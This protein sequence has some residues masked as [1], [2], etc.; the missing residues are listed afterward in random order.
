[1]FA[2]ACNKF[3]SNVIEKCL[4][5]LSHDA[6]HEMIQ[7]LYSVTEEEV[8]QMLQDSFG[9]YIIQ[10]SIALASIKDIWMI[11]EKL[12]PVLQRTPYGHKIES[13]L[14]RRLKGKPVSTRAQVSQQQTGNSNPVNAPSRHGSQSHG[15]NNSARSSYSNNNNDQYTRG[16]RVYPSHRGGQHNPNHAANNSAYNAPLDVPAAQEPW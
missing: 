14:E 3:S 4:F 15:G 6:Q 10:S 13:R 11:N 2:L 1:M 16:R 12:K 5:H 9:N 7:Q 8:F